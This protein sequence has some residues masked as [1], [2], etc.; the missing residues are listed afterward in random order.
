MAA[1]NI[2]REPTADEVKGFSDL[3]CIVRWSGLKGNPVDD[4]TQAGSLFRLCGVL[5]DGDLISIA[6][7]GAIDP[8]EFDAVLSTWTYDEQDGQTVSP[9]ITVMTRA[10]SF[11]RAAA[12]TAGTCWSR[13]AQHAYDTWTYQQ[14]GTSRSSSTTDPQFSTATQNAMELLLT[15]RAEELADS[16]KDHVALSKT[17]DV[18]KERSVPLMAAAEYNECWNRFKAKMD[19]APFPHEKP[20]CHQLTAM[21][22]ILR[23]GGCY[24]DFC[25]MGPN[26]VRTMKA[27]KYVAQIL[28]GGVVQET[29]MRGPPDF[30]TWEECWAIFQTCM[31]ML[32]A[33]SPSYLESYHAMIKRFNTTFCK[34]N[35][36]CWGLLYQA[37][38][39]F[40]HEH[41][42]DMMR[43]EQELVDKHLMRH[44]WDEDIHM[45]TQLPWQHMFRIATTTANEGAAE[46]EWWR[47]NFRDP[48]GFILH[49]VLPASHFIKG[50][51]P[52]AASRADHLP[53][54]SG[55]EVS[56]VP[57]S[58]GGRSMVRNDK[59]KPDKPI[60]AGKGKGSDKPEVCQK[61]NKGT[62]K[63]TNSNGMCATAPT[64]IHA[65]SLCGKK[66]HPALSCTGK[67]SGGEK[68]KAP[69]NVV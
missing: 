15:T 22:D 57:D 8:E 65:C 59:I 35:A 41:F 26:H 10:R 64:R 68:K 14:M 18:T 50:D 63:K 49:G 34:I 62:C 6:E 36:K 2:L 30:E 43:R 55:G 28:V 4:R 5:E 51:A 24:A 67:K 16:K 13:A 7:A 69:W 33:C 53:T 42:V 60:R 29:E 11:V 38:N 9:N 1:W 47:D 19:R 21:R 52:V 17:V 3:Q 40:R 31:I 45:D 54:M 20:S 61:Y 12:I 44:T 27:W 23:N 37:D 32:G 66:G 39:R 25:L 46:R 56:V 58:N 48:A